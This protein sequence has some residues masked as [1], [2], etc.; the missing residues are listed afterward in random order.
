MKSLKQTRSHNC[1]QTVVAMIAGI[2]IEKAEE[3]FGKTGMSNQNDLKRV[4]TML[5]Y[6]SKPF[7]EVDNRRKWNLPEGIVGIRIQYNNRKCGHLLVK[8][9][10]GKIYDPNGRVFT[11]REEM[12]A[13]FSSEC[14]S[15]TKISHIMPIQRSELLNVAGV[16]VGV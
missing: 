9:H 10:D 15:K 3:L 5:G 2:S 8:D 11:C 13:Y 14:R 12:L 1:G 4:L 7:Q 16:E 6:E